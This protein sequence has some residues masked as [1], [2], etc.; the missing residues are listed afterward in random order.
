MLGLPLLDP[1]KRIARLLEARS[2][3]GVARYGEVVMQVPRRATKTTAVLA[4]LIG[5][6]ETRPGYKA[7]WTAQTGTVASRILCEHADLLIRRGHAIESRQRNTYPG[8]I[9]FSAS[10]G[11][12]ALEW[13]SG[14]RIWCV[15]P[16]AGAVRSQAADTIVVDEAGELDVVKGRAFYNGVAPLL[17]TR[18]ALAQIVVM[19]TPAESRAGLL[20]DLLQLGREDEP[21]LGILD[22]SIRDGEDPEDRKVWRRVHPGPSSGLTPMATLEKRRL[23]LG[24]ESFGREYL[25]LWPVDASV[26]AIGG[27]DWAACAGILGTRPAHFV[28]AFDCAPD[29]SRAS[30]VAAWRDERGV[31]HVEVVDARAG[32]SWVAREAYRVARKYRVPVA[33][34]P[35]GANVDPAEALTRARPSIKTA[36]MTFR[37][38]QGGAAR[39][40]KDIRERTLAHGQQPDL[41]DAV[42]GA[43]WRQ[44]GDNGRLFGRRKS[45]A[46]VSALVAATAALWT[47]D[48]NPVAPKL[49]MVT[50]RSTG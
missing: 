9:W 26:A 6:A 32:T 30:L 50:R 43:S 3:P 33:Y 10:G 34:D 2:G 47:F 4:T 45:T 38:M 19:G 40:V 5:R 14:S 23:R 18:G 25:G 39:L 20:W 12:E 28:L 11:R 8:M 31:G 17:D 41:D 21:G 7:V 27:Q 16:D 13:P 36:P 22:W 46:D 1:G 42:A 49:A 44:V 48:A 24:P 35:I 29:A 15:P 37:D